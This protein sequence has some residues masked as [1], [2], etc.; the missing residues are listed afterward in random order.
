MLSPQI[1]AVFVAGAALIGR[2][3]I[4]A[5]EIIVVVYFPLKIVVSAAPD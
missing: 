1:G 4:N 2:D 5:G 3:G